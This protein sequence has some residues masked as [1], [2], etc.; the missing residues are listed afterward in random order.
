MQ[1]WIKTLTGLFV[2]QL[3]LVVLFNAS[4]LKG[5]ANNANTPLLTPAP[6]TATKLVI[7]AQNEKPVTLL[8][9]GDAWIMPDYFN[10]A[11][12]QE[13]LEGFLEKLKALEITWPEATTKA[14][15]TRFEVAEDKHQR[16]ISLFYGENGATPGPVLYLGTS[17]GYLK[18][19]ARLAGGDEIY[20]VKFSNYE[21][22]VGPQT[23]FNTNMLQLELGRINRIESD[24]SLLEQIEGEWRLADLGP[25]ETLDASAVKIYVNQ[26]AN[27]SVDAAITDDA[28]SE[29]A[30]RPTTATLK[31]Y[32]TG[33]EAPVTFDLA[34]SEAGTSYILKSSLS[35]LYFNLPKAQGDRLIDTKREDLLVAEEAEATPG[36]SASAPLTPPQDGA[37]ANMDDIPE[38]LQKQIEEMIRQQQLQ[39]AAPSGQGTAPPSHGAAS[40]H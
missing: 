4:L 13:K 10:L 39:G 32:L 36:T 25:E 21:A 34:L 12:N 16:Q 1:Q 7:Q 17:P 11:V 29:E 37:H 20:S 40:P 23:W 19:H 26:L 5:S 15:Q 18:T 33:S 2:I 9:Q 35:P 8:K 31:A 27:L 14:A 6:D 22:S 24:N 38:A 28:E 30:K 3:V